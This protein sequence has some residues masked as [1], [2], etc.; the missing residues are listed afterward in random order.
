MAQSVH[1]LLEVEHERMT[2]PFEAACGQSLFGRLISRGCDNLD[3]TISHHVG[4]KRLDDCCEQTL[5]LPIL[6]ELEADPIQAKVARPL[7]DRLDDEIP[8]AYDP[9]PELPL[10]GN[11]VALIRRDRFDPMDRWQHIANG[12]PLFKLG[13]EICIL[14]H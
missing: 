11:L 13:E 6:D 8:R 3:H 9:A 7:D 10:D 5:G 1:D 14:K 2:A 4:R 12:H